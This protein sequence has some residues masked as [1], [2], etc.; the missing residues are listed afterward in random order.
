[1]RTV[2]NGWVFAAFAAIYLI[3]GSTY[4]AILVGL[5]TIPPFLLAGLRFAVAGLALFG[6]CWARGE[7]PGWREVQQNSLSG[8]LM[9]FGGTGAVIWVEQHISSGL[10]AIVVASLPFW[11]VLL[12]RRQWGYYLSNKLILFGIIVGFTGILLL[13]KPVTHGGAAASAPW[14]ALAVLLGGCISWAAGSLYTKYHPTRLSTTFNAALQ[15]L[16]A[17]LFSLF[18]AFLAGETRTFEAAAVTSASWW[19]LA[20][21][22]VFGS[23]IGYLAYVW[24]LTIRPAVQVGTYAYVNPVV[25]VLLGWWF[26][27]EPL[28]GRQ[29][30]A[31]AIILLGV[32][33]I[34]LPRYGYRK[35]EKRVEGMREIKNG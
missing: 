22:I 5:E 34:N 12:D 8:I 31:L 16:A 28:A 15:T 27:E 13:F 6:W 23:L 29:L 10:A 18:V 4:L 2:S 1:M 21:L 32:L 14:F 9:L 35:V 3:W 19:A 33:L 24:L 7:R 30:A 20:Y 11:F 25:A 17:G 26:A